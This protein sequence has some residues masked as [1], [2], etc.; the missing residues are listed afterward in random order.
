MD[1]QG[2]V[3]TEVNRMPPIV[4]NPQLQIGNREIVSSQSND[5][6]GMAIVIVL[7][8]ENNYTIWSRAMKMVLGAKEKLGF[9]DGRVVVPNVGD[10]NYDKLKRTDCMRYGTS[11]GPMIY[12]LERE[13]SSLSQGNMT[14]TMAHMQKELGKMMRNSGAGSST[15]VDRVNFAGLGDFAGM[16]SSNL[17]SE[18]DIGDRIW[19]ID[20]C[21]TNY[22]CCN[23]SFFA[24]VSDVLHSSPITLPDGTR[25]FVTNTGTVKLNDTYHLDNCFFIPS[26]KYNLLSDQYSKQV[27]GI[28]KQHNGLYLLDIDSFSKSSLQKCCSTLF[29]VSRSVEQSGIY[30][31]FTLISANVWLNRLALKTFYLMVMNQF[32]TKIKMVRSDN[33]AEFLCNDCQNFFSSLGIINQR[34]CPY[35]PQQNGVVERK[36]KHL[37]Q[38]AWALMRQSNLPKEFWG[39]A[40]VTATYLIHRLPTPL[41]QWQTPYEKLHNKIPDIHHLRTFGCLC[42]AT[43]CSPSS[44]KF[45]HR[46]YKGIFIGY[47]SVH[48]EYK[49]YNPI[50]HKINMS[51]DVT[52]HENIFPYKA[53]PT[54]SIQTP[55]PVIFPDSPSKIIPDLVPVV[56]PP[57]DIQNAPLPGTT[58][59]NSESNLPDS[60]VIMRQSNRTRNKP[61]W[62]KDF[63]SFANNHHVSIDSLRETP[64]IPATFP[65]VF[66]DALEATHAIF[67]ANVSNMQEPV[68]YSQ[69]KNLVEWVQAMTEELQALQRNNTWDIVDLPHGKKPIGEDFT[70]SF[71]PVAKCVTVR[72]LLALAASKG[73]LIHQ[74]D[75]NNAFLHGT[76][77]EV[78]YMKPP[79]GLLPPDSK[80]VCKI[81]KSLYGLKQASR[82]WNHTF[83]SCLL[84]YGFTQSASDHCLFVKRSADI[85]LAL[86]V[87]V[88]D[89][90]V[91]S[92]SVVEVVAIKAHIDKSFTIKDLGLNLNGESSSL[93][94]DPKQ[95][96]R[97]VGRFLYLGFTRPDISYTIQQL[98]QFVH[99][100]REIHWTAALHVLKYLKGCPSHG[101]FYPVNTP[102]T[103]QSYCD[104]DWGSCKATR[105][106]L[107]GYCIFLGASLVSWKSK[108]QLTVSKSSAE[109]EYRSMGAT[110]CEL[111]WIS[112]VLAD[113]GCSLNLP[114]PLMC[115]NQAALHI[116]SN[117]VFHEWTKHLDIDCHIVRNQYLAGFIVPQQ[118][119]TKV[120]PADLFTKALHAP[121]F[122][123]LVPSWASVI[124]SS[125]NLRGDVEI[126]ASKSGE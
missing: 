102:V 95:Y 111:Q 112:Y 43:V 32:S 24:H 110:V 9:I 54:D 45:A 104:A 53:T 117:P 34:S 38:V 96:R 60:P 20:T 113:L 11:N 26:F 80:Q 30:S 100:P 120:Q 101:L 51:R 72:L 90:L 42:F 93:L 108:K 6:P 119:S 107:T 49:V 13:M 124:F 5:N 88:D 98:S 40:V 106:S 91:V 78:I 8:N 2:D 15:A 121:Q 46:S 31:G 14:V 61:G 50:T 28:G 65:F 39:E 62:L 35:T 84:A 89:V 86:L 79:Q 94:A 64:H 25:R 63:V 1:N 99:A 21:A 59:H 48:K 77:D 123:F 85:F 83:T 114:I 10:E 118:I 19:I 76:L 105:K 71:S 75:V 116:T 74:L 92:N 41:L 12:Q 115:D 122:Q 23:L 126:Y 27:V 3:Q 125:L 52:F 73:W 57:V 7:L 56:S 97:L 58:S 29:P 69:A 22:M 70:E 17:S 37:L 36:H 18:T 67:L 55:T 44:D 87:Y 4:N 16:S 47:S 66:H 82:Q 81:T 103:L 33:G 68:S 109:A